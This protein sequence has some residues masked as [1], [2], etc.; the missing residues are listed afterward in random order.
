M[1]G[2]A[3]MYSLCDL[4]VVVRNNDTHDTYSLCDLIVV[5]RN[6][7]THDTYSFVTWL[8]WSGTMIHM[9]HTHLWL[10]CCEQWQWYTWHTLICDLIV[11]VRDND[12]HATYSFVTW[13]LWTVTM[14]H[15]TH[16]HL[17]LDC[18]EQWQWYTLCDLIV[19]VRN[20]DTHCVT[21]LL[22]TVTMIHCVTWLLWTVTMIHCVTW[23]CDL[24]VVIIG[25]WRRPHGP[26]PNWS[27]TRLT[28]RPRYAPSSKSSITKHSSNVW[29][30]FS[31]TLTSSENI[32]SCKNPEQ[33]KEISKGVYMTNTVLIELNHGGLAVIWASRRCRGHQV[34]CVCCNK[35]CM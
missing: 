6:N 29:R 10:D 28:W 26:S 11:V 31:K 32:N 17:W 18:C 2:D 19:V 12:T 16:T 7:D 13:L 21:W 9:T 14:I 25:S 23:L 30:L 4:N 20:N 34:R 33:L 24:T 35:L 15:M 3:D 8:L 5:V 22:W 1:V 27:K